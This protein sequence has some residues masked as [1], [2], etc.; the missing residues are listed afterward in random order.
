MWST[1]KLLLTNGSSP[2]NISLATI[3][4]RINHL[5]VSC[6]ITAL[7][8][9]SVLFPLKRQT[10]SS[11]L[12]VANWEYITESGSLGCPLH[13]MPSPRSCFARNAFLFGPNRL[14]FWLPR[15]AGLAGSLASFNLSGIDGAEPRIVASA[16]RRCQAV[17]RPA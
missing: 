9:I 5:L 15:G 1:R 17:R 7:P 16:L 14:Q 2:L 12:T 10:L 8:D 4:F 11:W 6:R 3:T 13:T